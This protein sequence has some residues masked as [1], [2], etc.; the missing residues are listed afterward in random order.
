MLEEN[1]PSESVG[2]IK[3]P[4]PFMFET[5]IDRIFSTPLG[6]WTIYIQIIYYTKYLFSSCSFILNKVNDSAFCNC[7]FKLDVCFSWKPDWIG[8]VGTRIS[9]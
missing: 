7:R 8:K 3:G 6:A 1:Q 4:T 2:S 9:P 5:E